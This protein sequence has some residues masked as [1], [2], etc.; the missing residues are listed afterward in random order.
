MNGSYSYGQGGGY[1][2]NPNPKRPRRDGDWE[3]WLG[4]VVL[5][6]LPFGITQVIAVVWLVSKLRNM[7]RQQAQNYAFQARQAA[8]F[9]KGKAGAAF[10]G[11]TPVKRKGL[12]PG[13]VKMVV[14]GVMAGM[15]ALGTIAQLATFVES[16]RYGFFFADELVNVFVMLAGFGVG[17]GMLL[18]GREQRGRMERYTNYLAYIGANRQVSLAPMAAAMDVSVRRLTRDLRKMLA[19]HVLPT[20]YLD[21]KAGK[22]MLTEMGYT[23]PEPEPEP[24][25]EPEKN[26]QPSQEDEILREIR[27]INDLIPDPVIS[28]KID[29]IEEV[30]H[31]ILQYQKTHP[32]RT[33][34]LRTFLNY[35]LPTTLDILRSYA[36]L[37]AQGVEGENIT[38]AKQRIEGMMDK[39]VEGFEKQLDKL[40]SSDAMDIA[41]DVQVLENMLKKDGLSG[42]NMKL[43]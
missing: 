24:Q 39:V 25:P 36:R 35:Y 43:D 2:Y 37:D 30:T 1:H 19:T 15:F 42:D 20:G 6:L 12:A 9:V 5:F 18:T 10:G 14:G 32:Q 33:E 17:L 27:L 34:Q 40:F 26:Q 21:L 23:E 29:R 4:I 11:Q 3:D 16:L 41:A 31:K 7:T 22:L 13:T 28:A 8:E 38:A